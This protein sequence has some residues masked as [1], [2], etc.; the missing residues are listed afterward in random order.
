MSVQRRIGVF[1]RQQCRYAS[2]ASEG[3][4]RTNTVTGENVARDPSTNKEEK[5]SSLLSK[6]CN[7]TSCF[8]VE[9][10]PLFIQPKRKLTSQLQIERL[11]GR[12]FEPKRV[13]VDIGERMSVRLLDSKLLICSSQC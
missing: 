12:A 6:H 7:S 11:T 2:Q 9:F 4:L 10:R 8:K 1:L 3:S 13:R 5:V